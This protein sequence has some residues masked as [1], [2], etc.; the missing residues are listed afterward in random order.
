[1]QCLCIFM[2]VSVRRVQFALYAVRAARLLDPFLVAK[3][4][5]PQTR[6]QLHKDEHDSNTH[7][8]FYWHLSRRSCFVVLF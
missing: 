8:V 1:M 7:P 3:G 2:F 4:A 5:G 6:Q